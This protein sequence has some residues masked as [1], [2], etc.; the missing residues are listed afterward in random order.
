[1]PLPG[2]VV[3]SIQF[4]PLGDLDFPIRL[5]APTVKGEGCSM[6]TVLRKEIEFRS[7]SIRGEGGTVVP[8]IQFTS[9]H[10]LCHSFGDEIPEYHIKST[11]ES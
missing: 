9:K 2:P 11:T 5:H 8:F 3:I 4:T 10:S 1:M 6:Q 7:A